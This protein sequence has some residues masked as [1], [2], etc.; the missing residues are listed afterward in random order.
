MI[1]TILALNIVNCF[2]MELKHRRT[3]RRQGRFLAINT[4]KENSANL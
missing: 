2:E 1:P 3:K 4:T